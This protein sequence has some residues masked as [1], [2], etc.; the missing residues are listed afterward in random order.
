MKVTCQY[1]GIAFE[2][3]TARTKNHPAVAA[4]INEIANDKYAPSRAYGEAKVMMLNNKDQWQTVSE[5]L[6]AVAAEYTAWLVE[7][8]AEASAEA[9]AKAAT[10]KAQAEAW[11]KRRETNQ[12]LYK[13][14]FYWIHV[15]DEDLHGEDAEAGWS[16]IAPDGFTTTVAAALA[17]I[18][19]SK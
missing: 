17:T 14:G 3:Q 1:S 7:A 11:R 8:K 19:A 18:K 4:F 5:Y 12:V 9:K 10:A 2:A 6:A 13:A 15:T 16:L